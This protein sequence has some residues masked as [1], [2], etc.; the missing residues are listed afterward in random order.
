MTTPPPRRVAHVG[1]PSD[2]NG[3]YL[4]STNDGRL[5]R[6]TPSGDVTTLLDTTAVGSHIADFDYIPEKK[7]VVFPTFLDNRVSAYALE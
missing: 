4:V 6:I 2:E 5:L 7:M 3:D 1:V